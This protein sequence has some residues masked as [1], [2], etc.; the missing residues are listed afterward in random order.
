MGKSITLV[1]GDG[2]GDTITRVQDDTGGTARG[3]QGQHGLDGDVHGGGVE[4]LEHDLSHLL[5]V[6]LGV[7]GSLGEE[8]GVLLGGNT[9]LVVEGVMPDLLHVVPVGHDAVLDGVLEG[10]DTTLGLGLI[11]DVRVLLAHADHHTMVAR[12]TDDG[13]E[14]SARGIVTGETGLAHAGAVVNNKSGYFVFH[15]CQVVVVGGWLGLLFN[16]QAFQRLFAGKGVVS[17]ASR[18]RRALKHHD[19]GPSGQ[20]AAREWCSGSRLI[21]ANGVRAFA[22]YGRSLACGDI[23]C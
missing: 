14:H 1:D 6:G 15:C 22:I 16:S 4:G 23:S 2:V 10:Q 19:T 7:E 18:S 13:G 3:I 5:A 11:T 9:E 17:A 12:A 21:W 20:G 8:D